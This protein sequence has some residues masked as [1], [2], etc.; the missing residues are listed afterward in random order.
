MRR[1]MNKVVDLDTGVVVEELYLLDGKKHRDPSEGPAH[2]QRNSETG[3]VAWEFYYVNGQLHRTDG[4]AKIC[5]FFD[6]KVADETWYSRGLIHRESKDGPAHIERWRKGDTIVPVVTE[7]M[8]HGHHY[9][10]PKKGPYRIDRDMDG[11]IEEELFVEAPWLSGVKKSAEA[12]QRRRATK[13]AAP[14]E[15]RHP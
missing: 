10:D 5:Y 3:S 8:H 11:R 9:R 13:R 1:S 2:I 6:G 15:R 4:P 12:P 14:S 7:Y